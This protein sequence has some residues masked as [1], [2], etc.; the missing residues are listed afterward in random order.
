VTEPRA[1][2]A[3]I[4]RVAWHGQTLRIEEPDRVVAFHRR[5]Q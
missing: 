2:L 1:L 5:N 4:A 3:S